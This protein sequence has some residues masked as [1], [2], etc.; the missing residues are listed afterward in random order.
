[1]TEAQRE[2]TILSGLSVP[3]E[4]PVWQAVLL[5]LEE[6]ERGQTQAALLRDLPDHQ[7]QHLAGVACGVVETRNF[8]QALFD[9]AHLP[10]P[11]NR[12]D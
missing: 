11:M 6:F 12:Q 8:L 9:K 5:A 2:Q 3:R 4:N 10:A 7:R 1:M